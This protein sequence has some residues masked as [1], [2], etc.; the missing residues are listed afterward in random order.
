MPIGCASCDYFSSYSRIA[1]YKTSAPA[2]CT[3]LSKLTLRV[4][5]LQILGFQVYVVPFGDSYKGVCSETKEE[6]GFPLSRPLCKRTVILILVV[7]LIGAVGTL[8]AQ[9][10]AQPE[11][12]ENV[13]TEDLKN[14]SDTYGE[15]Q[16][17]QK[18]LNE[19]ISKLIN[20][21]SFDREEF[22]ALFQAQ[23]SGDQGALS[24][25]SES[26]QQESMVTA[27]EDEGLTVCPVV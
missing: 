26:K 16:E 8:G 22:H 13:T 27:I 14:F 7:F 6:C 3:Y 23:S 17:I 20:D 12:A 10:Q 5:R 25:L 24:N 21:S 15:V 2:M 9:T 4:N 11:A 1:M 18:S 19:K